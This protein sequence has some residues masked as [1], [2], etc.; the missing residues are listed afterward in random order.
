[1]HPY[2]PSGLPTGALHSIV[3]TSASV[4]FQMAMMSISS[5]RAVY[6]FHFVEEPSQR[7]FVE[8]TQTAP[9]A[10]KW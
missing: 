8:V 2:T 7:V 5:P 9:P 6:T 1:M 4:W 10:K 3:G